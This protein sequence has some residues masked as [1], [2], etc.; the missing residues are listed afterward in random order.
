[1]KTLRPA[2]LLLATLAPLPG[3]APTVSNDATAS[4]G[5]T[6]ADGGTNRPEEAAVVVAV[7]S[8]LLESDCPDPPPAKPSAPESMAPSAAPAKPVKRSTAA[9]APAEVPPMP[10]DSVAPPRRRRCQ[11]STLQITF[12]N[13]AETSTKVRVV[14]VRLRDVQTD[15]QVATLA[16]RK[17]SKWSEA[18]NAYTAWDENLAGGSS[19][20]TSYRIK[21]PSWSSVEARLEGKPSR[22]RTYDVEVAVEVD[23]SPT[24][25]RSAEFTRPPIVPMPPT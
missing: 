13:K 24:T 18:D 4:G 8:V 19:A 22:G 16:S 17:P 15:Q 6:A 20:R 11:Q 1:M 3:C 14:E 9:S 21:P 2:I 23:G 12:E 25:A 5:K 10:G 7:G